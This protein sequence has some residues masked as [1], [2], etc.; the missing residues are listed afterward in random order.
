MASLLQTMRAGGTEHPETIMN[1]LA[2]RLVTVAGIFD[3][4]GTQ[5]K[6]AQETVPAMSVMV[7]QGY[8][9]IPKSDLS[10]TYPV[11]LNTADGSVAI[12]ANSSGSTRNDA[13][14][15]YIDLSASANAAISNVAK[16]IAVAGTPGG[17]APTDGDISTAIGASNPFIRL[18]DV[19]VATGETAIETAHITDQRVA[20]TYS[21][22][23][24]P[25]ENQTGWIDADETWTYSSVDDPT[26]VITV[27]TNAT[28]K[29]SVGM[30]I[31]FV[32][33]GN[34]I[35]GIITAVAATTITFLHEIDPTD[36]LALYLMANS[37]ITVPYFS[38]QKAPFGFPTSSRKWTFYKN[39]VSTTSQA[40]PTGGTWYN[41][42]SFSINIPIGVWDIDFQ[43]PLYGTWGVS[44]ST[45]QA[46]L[47]TANNS[48]SDI[49]F[50]S[51]LGGKASDIGGSTLSVKKSLALT[52]KTT[53]YANA[54][55]DVA[56]TTLTILG[57]YAYGRIL[58]K[59][60]YL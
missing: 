24:V 59:C 1:F 6:V 29:Y 32:N 27:P 25:A 46:T 47:S 53:Y 15:L 56:I 10:M 12:T 34:T 54:R 3:I 8:A 48:E 4:S 31:R 9:F 60:A 50:S 41:I 20:A 19:E 30:R 2:S 22:N 40:T 35:Y 36:S 26:G 42:G 17:A 16:L 13:I 21:T 57:S 52:S 14:V 55:C 45:L 5:F 39:Y 28:T 23:I 49:E 7:Q 51:I 43:Y 38:T 33:G 58:C 37:A 18:A 11:Q 44:T